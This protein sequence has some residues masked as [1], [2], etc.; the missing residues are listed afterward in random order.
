MAGRQPAGHGVRVQMTGSLLPRQG[1]GQ[2]TIEA[3]V[4]RSA[5]QLLEELPLT[6]PAPSGSTGSCLQHSS[7]PATSAARLLTGVVCN[8][9]HRK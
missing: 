3:R 4:Q 2:L 8:G 1:G 6:V 9:S 5:L 7:V